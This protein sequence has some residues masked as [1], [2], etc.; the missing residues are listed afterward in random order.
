[1]ISDVDSGGDIGHGGIKAF[2]KVLRDYINSINKILCRPLLKTPKLSLKVQ[3][4]LDG[5]V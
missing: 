2:V 4:R 5:L 1:M 3:A